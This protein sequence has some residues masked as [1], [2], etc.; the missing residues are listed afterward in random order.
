MKAHD[1]Y[2]E[3][4]LARKRFDIEKAFR[5]FKEATIVYDRDGLFFTAL[6]ECQLRMKRYADAQSSLLAATKLK[7]HDAKA[8]RLLSSVY[9]MQDN[10]EQAINAIRKALEVAPSDAAATAQL[11]LL[12]ASQGQM[13]EADT[14]FDNSRRL[15]RDSG[16]YW[17]LTGRYY[18]LLGKPQETEAAFRQAV[19]RDPSAEPEYAEWLGFVLR[20]RA[21]I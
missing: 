9:A 8:W 18:K 6:G 10:E 15:D 14:T 2:R 4:M 21:K 16:E 3:G 1:L 5:K 11:G 12:L 17:N 20:L 19:S 7:P 13:K